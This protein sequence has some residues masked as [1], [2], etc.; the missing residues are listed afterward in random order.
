MSRVSCV[1][2]LVTV[3]AALSASAVPAH[4]QAAGGATPLPPIGLPLPPI[5]L[6]LP[7]IGLDPPPSPGLVDGGSRR[8]DR[9]G[10][11][12]E[13]R[14]GRRGRHGRTLVILGLP[15]FA[16]HHDFAGQHDHEAELDEHAGEL[17]S[18]SAPAPVAQRGTLRLLIDVHDDTRQQVQVFVDG[19]FVG[20]LTDL[21]SDLALE[22]GRR[23][24]EL[25]APSHEPLVFDVRIAAGEVIVYRGTLAPR[26]REVA[27]SP[28]APSSAG[29]LQ[30]APV[31]G[32]STFYLIPGCYLGNVPP[33]RVT[34]PPGCEGR[35]VVRQVK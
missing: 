21:G 11:R 17:M 3:A 14:G 9:H 33:E 26:S 6:P 16:G 10:R 15:A 22:S 28:A 1:V 8:D 7:R 13:H 25:R 27:R 30:P 19:V 34:L 35:P 2:I 29:A 31:S 12:G 18:D 5:G 24:I 4:A 23:R 20:M 32:S